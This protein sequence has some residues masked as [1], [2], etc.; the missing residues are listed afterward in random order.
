MKTLP[1]GVNRTRDINLHGIHWG[2]PNA[3]AGA[4]PFFV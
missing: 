4:Q 3:F 1:F 2:F